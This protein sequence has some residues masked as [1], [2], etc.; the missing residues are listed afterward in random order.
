MNQSKEYIEYIIRKHFIEHNYEIGDFGET[1]YTYLYLLNNCDKD[2]YILETL[3]K[4]TMRYEEFYI[5]CVNDWRSIKIAYIYDGIIY[6]GNFYIGNFMTNLKNSY[7]SKIRE[8][9]LNKL[10]Y[11]EEI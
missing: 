10:I 8:K 5:L 7:Y 1:V 11:E 9:T 3:I 6:I 2:K 4:P